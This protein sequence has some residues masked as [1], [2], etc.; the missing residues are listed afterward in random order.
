MAL[1][2]QLIGLLLMLV[3]VSD[4]F[5]TVLYARSET[6]FLARRYARIVWRVLRRVAAWRGSRHS[7]V[8]SLCGPLI[9]VTVV[10]FWA[11]GLAIGAGLII[12]PE[13]GTG[14]QTSS[15][16]TPTDFV[17]A[18][19]AGGSSLSIVGAADYNPTTTLMK[20]LYLFNSL[21]GAVVL[22]VTLTY[23][24]QIYTA[25]RARNTLAL[26]LHLLS[27]ETD[28]AVELVAGLGPRGQFS[29][30]YN[31]ISQLA[32]QLTAPR[33]PCTSIPR[34]RTSALRRRITRQV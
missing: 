24:M 28:D 15:A 29:G 14:V 27:G 13:L 32:L 34:W 20:L 16:T 5:L 30:G 33:R 9:L 22:S 1:V 26:D 8:L 12:H 19:E 11:I 21:V 4:V 17:S 31:H 10:G 18:V 3:I 23:I 25:L 7:T 2:E 6:G